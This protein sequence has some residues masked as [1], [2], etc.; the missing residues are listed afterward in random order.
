VDSLLDLRP[1]FGGR[2]IAVRACVCA[3]D[4]LRRPLDGDVAPRARAAGRDLVAR[5][6]PRDRHLPGAAGRGRQDR[7]AAPM[8]VGLEPVAALFGRDAGCLATAALERELAGVAAVVLYPGRDASLSV[9]APFAGRA[10][11]CWAGV[12]GV[13]RRAGVVRAAPGRPAERN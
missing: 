7:S 12:V 13:L 11:R 10:A 8:V 4:E 9:D 6:L 3:V 5:R 1:R 2:A